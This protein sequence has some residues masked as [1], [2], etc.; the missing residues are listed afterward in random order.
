[1]LHGCRVHGQGRGTSR[2]VEVTK[3]HSRHR[4]RRAAG[5]ARAPRTRVGNSHRNNQRVHARHGGPTVGKQTQ[6]GEGRR[7]AAHTQKLRRHLGGWGWCALK[8]PPTNGSRPPPSACGG[9]AWGGGRVGPGVETPLQAAVRLCSSNPAASTVCSEHARRRAGIPRF[10]PA[11]CF[12][13]E[14]PLRGPGWVGAATLLLG[15]PH[16]CQQPHACRPCT[17]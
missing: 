11:W 7:G 5:R 10:F 9:G 17:P 8:F 13:C 12:R 2:G 1:M 16:R 14:G 6:A 15:I 3:W 4:G